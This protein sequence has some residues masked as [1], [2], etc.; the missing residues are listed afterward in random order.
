[1]D[2]AQ[3]NVA[4]LQLGIVERRYFGC[5]VPLPAVGQVRAQRH[6]LVCRTAGAPKSNMLV[7]GPLL[8]EGAVER[9]LGTDA[10]REWRICA[11]KPGA[12][13]ADRIASEELSDPRAQHPFPV[14]EY[15]PRETE[16][17]RNQVVVRG[18]NAAILG[19]H[20]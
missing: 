7:P 13:A 5:K 8:D 18:N 15:I 17:R 9:A 3:A 11:D 14:A 2:A 12:S 19:M 4:D 6:A 16:A 10:N 20:A 1:M